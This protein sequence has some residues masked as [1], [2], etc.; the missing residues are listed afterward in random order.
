MEDLLVHGGCR[1][2]SLCYELLWDGP[3]GAEPDAEH[4]R[5][6][7]GLTDPAEIDAQAPDLRLRP[8]QLG[9]PGAQLGAI[10]PPS[11]PHLGGILDP[12]NAPQTRADAGAAADRPINGAETHSS[13]ADA[14]AVRR[15]VVAARG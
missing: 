9:V 1:G 6:L 8:P 12:S 13:V 5:H 14:N 7:C 3:E 15:N 4:R 10:L 11:W 2:H